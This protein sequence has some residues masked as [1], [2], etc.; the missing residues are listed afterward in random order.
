[1]RREESRDRR[2]PGLRSVIHRA[3]L[4]FCAALG[5]AAVT[6]SVCAFERAEMEVM[7]EEL[8]TEV[9]TEGPNDA[10]I[11]DAT[12]IVVDALS[13]VGSSD[14][15][16]LTAFLLPDEARQMLNSLD[17]ETMREYALIIDRILRNPDFQSLMQHQEVQ[18]LI[19]LLIQ[20][21]LKT[22]QEEP[23]LTTQVLETLGLDSRVIAL[24]YEV[25]KVY[26][27]NSETAQKVQDFMQTE[28]GRTLLNT[29][30]TTFTPET[31]ETLLRSYNELTPM[32]EN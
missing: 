27:N 14:E 23:E 6:G 24:F 30:L 3:G 15:N 9:Q 25:L 32:P 11:G 10:L 29:I 19:S 1:M 7:E 17:E 26:E 12:H 22:A 2:C 16:T 31:I 28:E 21:G 18:D 5:C 4:L 8:V 20:N 13:S